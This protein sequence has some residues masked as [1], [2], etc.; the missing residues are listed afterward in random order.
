[1]IGHGRVGT[2]QVEVS[3]VEKTNVGGSGGEKVK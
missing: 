3:S 2:R 1:V